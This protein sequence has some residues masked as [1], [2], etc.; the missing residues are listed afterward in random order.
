MKRL[1]SLLLTLAMLAA[2]V[3]ATLTGVS[4]EDDTSP[5]GNWTDEGNFDLSWCKT[6]TEAKA[7]ETLELNGKFYHIMGAATQQTYHITKPEQLAGLAYLSNK[8]S[9]DLFKG[10]T[11]YI[12]A[13]LDL[14]AHYWVPIC[15]TDSSKFRG[16]IIGKR[17]GVD[18]A[19]ATITGMTID[20]SATEGRRVGLVGKFG[21]GWIKNLKLTNASIKAHSYTVGSFVGYQDGNV[22]SWQPSNQGGYE[23]LYADTKI[24]VVSGRS[25]RFDD[26]G[27]IVGLINN[28]NGNNPAAMIKGCAFTG[29]IS[30]PMGDNVGGIVG[31]SQYDNQKAPVISNCVVVSEKLECGETYFNQE[32][33]VGFGGIAGN[34]YSNQ[35]G[36]S[37]ASTISNCYVAANMTILEAKTTGMTFNVGGIVGASCS[38]TKTYTNC[39]FDGIIT[40]SAARKGAILGRCLSGATFRNCMATG[41]VLNSDGMQ[42]AYAGTQTAPTVDNCFSAIPAFDCF[43]TNSKAQP[44]ITADTDLSALLGRKDENGNAIWTKDEGALYP[45]L[46]VAK[47]YL[48]TENRHLSVALSGADFT[49]FSF[50]EEMTLTD[51]RELLALSLL[52]KAA[53]TQAVTF[54]NAR[55]LT[56]NNVLRPLLDNLF[57]ADAAEA[58]EAKIVSTMD[59]SK[60]VSVFAQTSKAAEDGSYAVRF[61]AEIAGSDW[62]SAGFELLVSYTAEDGTRKYSR[63]TEQAVTVCYQSILADGTPIAAPDGHYYLV[64]VLNGIPTSYGDVTFTVSA[65]VEDGEGNSYANAGSVVFASDGKP[66]SN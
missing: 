50:S 4:A 49:S 51:A 42:S 1:I 17:N 56:L 64:F 16:S 44:R 14:S 39:Q 5:K 22:G 24:E 23:N 54:L 29:T 61:V 13:D 8:A 57:D 2:I 35:S 59:S 12:E 46:A 7:G 28:C 33:N 62:A 41:V 63:L 18:D 32:W 3:P 43:G 27:G 45:I 6:L 19:I 40:G 34:I 58:L 60:V 37:V 55:K 38:Q 52:T 10:D 47:P 20:T 65:Q 53:G 9:G 48:T 31:L 21:G 30:A 26:I 25:D 15:W 66:K 11:F 36:D